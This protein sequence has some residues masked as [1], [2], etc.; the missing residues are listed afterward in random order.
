[1]NDFSKK[2]KSHI[3]R[4]DI[5]ILQL[6]KA[7]GVDRTLIQ[8]I[9]TGTRLPAERKTV[10]KI[11]SV[12]MLTTQEE[13][14]LYRLYKISKM[15]ESV[16]SRHMLVKDLIEC[17][18]EKKINSL[19]NVK[20]EYH[21]DFSDFP[22]LSTVIGS[23]DVNA[24]FKA[25]IESE[26]C[27]KDGVIQILMQPDNE[28][29]INLL[30]MI[31]N[32]HSNLT[33]EHVFCLQNSI[34]EKDDNFYNITCI[35]RI[36]P[37][38]LSG[39]QYDPLIYYDDVKAHFS[40]STLFPFVVLTK[41][42]MMCISNDY[43][44]AMVFQEPDFLE[45][46]QSSYQQIKN[47]AKPLIVKLNN[48][49]EN[50]MYYKEKEQSSKCVAYELMEQPCFSWFL[51]EDLMKKYIKSD[52]QCWSDLI[53]DVASRAKRY[54]EAIDNK[55]TLRSYFSKAGVDNFLKTGRIDEIPSAIYN[56]I[57]QEDCIEIIKQ[58]Y[59]CY[60][61]GSYYTR[62]YD[63]NVLKLNRNL[64]VAS[65]D[66]STICFVYNKADAESVYFAINEPSITY[67]IHSF[68]IYIE[69]SDMVL[70]EKETIEFIKSKIEENE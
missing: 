3:A 32:E 26:A 45:L 17:F 29:L 58:M 49:I 36:A 52:M 69:E 20:S 4:L 62:L 47:M 51:T 42:K 28:V 61:G 24:I 48:I 55:H 63:N 22:K 7:S 41:D 40:R 16:Y 10:E 33:I 34:R 13:E 12:M 27:K 44:N 46:Y 25:I 2:L 38:L 14:E 15:G 57:E 35:K 56:P 39:C 1:M 30:T 31:G 60:L 54:Q 65:F 59:R 66:E 21:H 37:L 11:I 50:Y 8:K 19:C 70:S 18:G 6:S 9:L 43:N 64:T 5:K 68:L 23:N 53:S 67:A